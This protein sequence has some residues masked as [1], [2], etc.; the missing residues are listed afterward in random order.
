MSMSF[1]AII[2][3]GGTRFARRVQVTRQIQEELTTEFE[4][5]AREFLSYSHTD[6]DGDGGRVTETAERISFFPLYQLDDRSQ[7]FEEANYQI[8]QFITNVAQNPDAVEPLTLDDQIIS[9]IKAFCA[10]TVTQRSVKV[11]FQAFDRRRSLTQRSWTFLQDGR[12]F[13]RLNQ[14]GFTLADQIHA[15]YDNGTLLFRSFSMA[16]RFLELAMMFNEAS[17]EKAEEVLS[18]DIFV[19]EDSAA[20]LKTADSLMRKQFAAISE[21]GILDK[22]KPSEVK[23]IAADFDIEI[24]VRRVKGK[25]RLEFPA[26]KKVQ[27]G[28]LKVLTESYYIGPVSGEKFQSNSHRPLKKALKKKTAK[29]AAKAAPKAAKKKKKK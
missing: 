8:D 21:L 19:V 11:Y 1:F 24:G 23:T 26:E 25:D 2:E 28:L 12:T 7:I 5:Q 16:A 14:P 4:R 13:S 9:K 17:N 22:V 15:I 20:I 18:H 27:K 10:A 3:S 6:Q 29:K